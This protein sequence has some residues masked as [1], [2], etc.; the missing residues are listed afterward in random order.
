MSN[1]FYACTSLINL[2]ISNF[3]TQNVT[4]MGGMFN[5][6]ES[7]NTI[8]VSHFNTIILLLWILCSMTANL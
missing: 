6:C 4:D 5:G 3:N 8:D 7:L 1:M 2:D